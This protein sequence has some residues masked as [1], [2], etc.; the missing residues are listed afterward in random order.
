MRG[1]DEFE[2]LMLVDV[3]VIA[4]AFLEGQAQHRQYIHVDAVAQH[5]HAMGTED[6]DFLQQMR[7][8]VRYFVARRF[9]RYAIGEGRAFQEIGTVES[10][11]EAREISQCRFQHGA[12]GKAAVKLRYVIALAWGQQWRSIIHAHDD[13]IALRCFVKYWQLVFLGAAVVACSDVI[14]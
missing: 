10:V 7:E 8:T 2:A 13:F 1:C 5:Q 6:F 9:S 3:E 14:P 11:A 4:V 12:C